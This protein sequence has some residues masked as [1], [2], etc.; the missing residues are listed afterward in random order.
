MSS[1]NGQERR[2]GLRLTVEEIDAVADRV[3]ERFYTR[4]GR[5]VIKKVLVWLGV[6]A[7]S[8]AVGKGWLIR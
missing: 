5:Q 4:L 8:F 3:E 1:Y 7:V 6:A 2:K